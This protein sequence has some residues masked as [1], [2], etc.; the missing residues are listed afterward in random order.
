MKNRNLSLKMAALCFL[1]SFGEAGAQD[2]KSII[3]NHL[4]A[5]SD[6]VKPSLKSFEIINT[7]FSKSMKADVVKFQQSYNGIPVYNSVGTALIKG[8]QVSYLNENF[9]KNFVN[10]A[11]P[12]SAA[13]EKTVFNTA[14]QSLGLKNPS[15]YQLIGINDPE[16]DGHAAV[17]NRL[18]Y[19]LTD[20][21]NLQLCYEFIFEEKGTS[22]YWNI[23]AD[24]VTG[25]IL[26]KNNLTLS[27]NFRHDAYNHHYSDHQP[28]GFTKTF[29]ADEQS[30]A[31]MAKAADNASYRVFALPVE[32]PTHGTRSLVNNPWFAD[33]S[34]DGWHKI[35]GGTYAGDYTITRGNNV[36]AYEDKNNQN[37]PG[38][39]PDGGSARV[40]DFPFTPNATAANLRA[41]TTNLFYVNN[42]VH[43][44]FYRLGFTETAR[45]FQAYN[46]GKGGSQNDYVMAEAHD[47]GGTNNANFATPIDGSRPR[48]Q[49]YLW[50]PAVLQRVF[51]NTPPEAVGRVVPNGVSNTF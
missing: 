2:Y 47:G 13:A 11:A 3:Q 36:H 19:L 33:A 38:E 21:N 17:R 10:A 4:A 49:M 35:G 48:M 30:E 32:S 26:V 44:I 12:N 50:D 5:K 24:A 39:S 18:I 45:N 34:P 42:K 40:F 9:A 51:Y 46:F 29:A 41:A 27:C 22:N 31:G 28:E 20:Q 43:D 15:A 1:F 14:A 16:E 25:E 7:D 6:F 23:L 37:G 8:T